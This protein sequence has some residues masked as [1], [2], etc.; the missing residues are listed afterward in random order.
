MAEY[1]F[2]HL[3]PPMTLERALGLLMERVLAAGRRALVR[4][5]SPERVAALDTGLWTWN[6]GSFVPHGAAPDPEA[7][8]QP[9]WLTADADN[10]NGADVLALVD[11]VEPDFAALD[12]DGFTR[13]L[14][15]FD[16]TDDAAVEAARE[17]WRRAKAQGHVVSYWALTPEGRW[18]KRA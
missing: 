3:L 1:S 18:E 9:V 17:R 7:A 2:Y 12:R 8:R 6:D 15:I 10:P 11:G 5:G 4:A 16:G 14:D 13:C